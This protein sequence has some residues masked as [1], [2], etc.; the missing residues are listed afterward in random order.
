MSRIQTV[1][2]NLEVIVMNLRPRIQAR[3]LEGWSPKP[4]RCSVDS[5]SNQALELWAELQSLDLPLGCLE[6]FFFWAEAVGSLA[7]TA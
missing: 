6:R 1:I 7:G 5:L 3:M 4:W 2:V